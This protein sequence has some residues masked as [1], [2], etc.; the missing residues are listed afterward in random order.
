[1]AHDL[2]EPA[3]P[4][5]RL[6]R[7]PRW[8][9]LAAPVLLIVGLVVTVAAFLVDA[10]RAWHAYLINWLWAFSIAQGAVLLAVIVTITKGL[11]SRP[12]RRI[13]LSFVAYLPISYLLLIP[14][15]IGRDHIFPWIEVPAAG[16]E[17]YLNVPFM[18][19]RHFVGLG[20]L[21]V[22]S[23]IFAYWS[24][25]PDVGL[26]RPDT[27]GKLRG[28]YDRIAKNWRGQETEER[29]AYQRIAVLGPIFAIVYAIAMSFVAWDMIMSLEP[30]WFSTLIGP[31]FFM[32]A[33]LGGIAATAIVTTLHTR[34]LGLEPVILP[35]HFHDLGKLTFAFCVFWAYLFFSQFIVIW[36]GM[37]PHEQAFIIHRFGTPYKTVAQL[38]FLG[39]FVIPFGGLLGVA[40]KKR[41]E[42][43]SL[44]AGIVLIGLWLERYLLVYPSLHMD[45]DHVPLGWQE[46]GMGLGFAGLLIGSVLLFATRFPLFQLWQPLGEL[47]LQGVQIEDFDAGIVRD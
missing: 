3:L 12:I 47:E 4:A 30:H 8:G 26:L 46:I 6:E 31:Y 20:L 17:A 39:L 14:I 15:Y 21:L 45:V 43:L 36:Y 37:L 25:R 2:V 5:T 44:F 33:L 35:N 23:F 18:A 10:E 38:V 27:H 24:L 13:A 11:W 40:P 9:A 41:P 22:V 42:I 19:V 28:L 32:A 29:I 1:M 34:T 16:K 7:F